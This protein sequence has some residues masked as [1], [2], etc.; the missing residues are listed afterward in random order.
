MSCRVFIKFWWRES[1][2]S[3]NMVHTS[4][5]CFWFNTIL[6]ISRKPKLS[7]PARVC[8]CVNDFWWLN[9]SKDW[10]FKSQNLMP[11]EV[12]GS[13]LCKDTL[14]YLSSENPISIL[15][16][17]RPL[18]SVPPFTNT[19]W[20]A[21]VLAIKFPSLWCSATNEHVSKLIKGTHN[22]SNKI[23]FARFPRQ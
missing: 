4:C 2:R 1:K 9:Y 6:N 16:V 23:I 21:H 3:L 15:S 20:N 12:I 8:S 11:K 22:N 7:F 17:Y 14:I 13:T 19:S 18:Y 10:T 5:C